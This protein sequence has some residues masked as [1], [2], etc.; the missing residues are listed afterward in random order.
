M[1]S[2]WKLRVRMR[3]L[4][5]AGFRK[6][7]D[8][9]SAAAVYEFAAELGTDGLEPEL[10]AVEAAC[11]L[12]IDDG[13]H[14]ADLRAFQNV[15]AWCGCVHVVSLRLRSAGET[16]TLRAGAAYTPPEGHDGAIRVST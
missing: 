1:S 11:A 7:R 2:T 12:Q 4:G 3:G 14:A 9:G 8:F 16:F 15:A 13:E 10:L 6:E 5:A